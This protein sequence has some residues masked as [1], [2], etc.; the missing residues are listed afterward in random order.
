GDLAARVQRLFDAIRPE[1][2]L[3]RQNWFLYEDPQLHQPRLEFEERP[4]QAKPYLRSERQTLLRLPGSRAVVF[5]IHTYVL[6]LDALTPDQRA[7]L[8]AQHRAGV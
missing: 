8:D 2:P 6:A 1:Q 3:W 4:V 5:G 7:G